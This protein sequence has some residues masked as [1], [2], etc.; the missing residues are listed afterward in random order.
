[1]THCID[2][3]RYCECVMEIANVTMNSLFDEET[4]E[5]SDNAVPTPTGGGTDIHPAEPES[6]QHE[7]ETVYAKTASLEYSE[8]L[9]FAYLKSM[10][11]TVVNSDVYSSSEYDDNIELHAVFGYVIFARQSNVPK[12]LTELLSL[13]REHDDEQT[14]SVED[15]QAASNT[16]HSEPS[17]DFAHITKHI[18][19]AVALQHFVQNTIMFPAQYVKN[20]CIQLVTTYVQ[21]IISGVF[22][23]TLTQVD[24][25]KL[26]TCQTKIEE[27]HNFTLENGQTSLADD[28]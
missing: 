8:S 11:E 20:A 5:P 16:I 21:T 12:T 6:A 25:T 28:A 17:H 10:Y 24:Y 3:T 19:N 18:Q 7:K 1:M 14:F 2:A 15:V 26:T 4:A 9:V 22:Y 23:T 13:I 27:I